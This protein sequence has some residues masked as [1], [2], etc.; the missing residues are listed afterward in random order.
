MDV[1][2][3]Q[4]YQFT[5]V[6]SSPEIVCEYPGDIPENCPLVIDN[7]S[8]Q[9]R[10]GWTCHDAPSLVFK[11][12]VARNRGN[13]KDR[14]WDLL[15]GN[16]IQDLE[17]VRWMVRTAFDFNVV[18]NFGIQENILDHTF[19]HLGINTED[20]VRHPLVMTESTANPPHSRKQM[21]ELLFEAYGIPKLAYGVDILFSYYNS[22]EELNLGKDALVIASGFQSTHVLPII[23]GLLDVKNCKRI[24]LGGYN[25]GAY[26][27]R[28]LQLRY[29][30]LSSVFTLTRMDQ[31]LRDVGKIPVNYME[32]VAKWSDPA[33][34][35][36]NEVMVQIPEKYFPSSQ[37]PNPP[38]EV[39]VSLGQK[40]RRMEC[41]LYDLECILELEEENPDAFTKTLADFGLIDAEELND[42]ISKLHK[43][44]ES[45]HDKITLIQQNSVIPS[46][47]PVRIEK[48]QALEILFQPM[49]VGYEQAG[50][51]EILDTIFS[52]YDSEQCSRMAKNVLITGGNTQYKGFKERI[53]SELT[54]CRPFG[55]ECCV[56]EAA[57]PSLDAWNGARL[58]AEEHVTQNDL[59]MSKQDFDEFGWEYMREHEVSNKYYA[60]AGQG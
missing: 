18:V 3:R 10:A 39:T 31:F 14:D 5:D 36:R 43:D 58:W 45:T 32:E 40:L 11:N 7:G 2:E 28:L 44:V 4:S 24:N 22:R 12:V 6:K 34:A 50:V 48:H 57:D 8:Y 13:R 56:Q 33:F 60:V 54:A 49:L 16:D 55:S 23:S 20:D 59:W 9:L 37:G 53:I 38:C 35:A 42:K 47:V 25:N 15:V 41:S 21:S 1:V 26:L 19:S 17:A 52:Q 30:K 46:Q 29:P 51:G 27:Q